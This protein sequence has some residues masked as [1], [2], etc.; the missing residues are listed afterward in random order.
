MF[1]QKILIGILLINLT[2]SLIL[3]EKIANLFILQKNIFL[4]MKA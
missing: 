4:L 3:L 1:G 2:I